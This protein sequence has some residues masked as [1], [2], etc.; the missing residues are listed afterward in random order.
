MKKD[1]LKEA[2]EATKAYQELLA[3]LQRQREELLVTQREVTEALAALD[4][5]LQN[6]P[7]AAPPA[8]TPEAVAPSE[9]PTPAEE[10]ATPE[11]EVEEDEAEEAPA[12]KARTK[13]PAAKT[14]KKEEAPAEEAAPEAEAQ[15][16]EEEE[17]PEPPAD[18]HLWILET[19]GTT[20]VKGSDLQKEGLRV[21]LKRV[22]IARALTELNKEKKVEV[23]GKHF[24]TVA[25]PP[26]SE[27]EE[28][29]EASSEEDKALSSPADSISSAGEIT[30]EA[31]DDDFSF[32]QGD[33]A[34]DDLDDLPF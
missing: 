27:A 15:Q 26:S 11:S 30:P 18:V 31:E 6:G 32:P 8:A 20:G 2:Q 21:G 13:K 9:D 17:A 12:P 1:Y 29:A 3:N 28:G 10:E 33:T 19:V 4:A 5:V 14:T 24:I 25:A 7:L 22:A 34:D 16:E 23:D